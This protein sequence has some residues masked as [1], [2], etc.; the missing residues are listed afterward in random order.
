ML[1]QY[2]NYLFIY[3]QK[4]AEFDLYFIYLN[5]LLLVLIHL[6]YINNHQYPLNSE[7]IQ[8]L[9]YYLYLIKNFISRFVYL[10]IKT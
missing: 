4:I 8:Y 3:E 5:F 7:L 10:K 9:K 6:Q 1:T 2:A